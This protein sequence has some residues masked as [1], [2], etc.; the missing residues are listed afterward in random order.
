MDKKQLL[1][2]LLISAL[3]VAYFIYTKPDE[4]TIKAQQQ[5][6]ARLDSIQRLTDSLR[7]DSVKQLNQQE[8]SE[9]AA[10]IPDSLLNA[11]DSI[12]LAKRDS[13]LSTQNQQQF[14]AFAAHAQGEAER[15]VLENEFLRLE[16]L[17]KGARLISA[18]L[19]DYQTYHDHF[20]ENSE[21][22]LDLIHEGAA[23]LDLSFYSEGKQINTDDLYFEASPIDKQGLSFKVFAGAPD[24]YLEWRYFLPKESRMLDFSVH[25][26]N[27]ER[28]LDPGQAD[29]PLAWS[30]LAPSQELD[31]EIERSRTT[32]YYQTEDES[33]SRI[34][35]GGANEEEI[36]ESLRWIS[37]KQQ[38][39]CNALILNDGLFKRPVTAKAG[40]PNEEDSTVNMAFLANLSLPYSYQPQ[41]QVSMRW[42]LGPLH[43]QTLAT[44]EIGLEDQIDLGYI[45][46]FTWINK[47]LI[48]P[49]FNFF[50][51][52]GLGYGLIILLLT[53]IIK[54]LLSPLNFK[55]F[56]SSA[57]MRILK[58]EVDELSKK[59]KP[60]E[61]MKK[62]Q[63]VMTL[64]RQAGVNPLAGCLPML[65]QMPFLLAMFSFFP[66]AIELRQQGFLWAEDLS[67]YDSIL[68]LPFNIPFYGSHVSLF[69]LL[70]TVTTILYTRMTS[71]QMQTGANAQ[72][73]KIMMYVMPLIFLGVLNNYS[74]ALSYYY[75]LSNVVSIGITLA[76][77]KF[78]IDEDKLR[79]K[80]E[81]NKQNPKKK[82]K[83]MR[84]LEEAQKAKQQQARQGNAP[85]NRRGR[86]QGN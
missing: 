22:A 36:D 61:A 82:S 49:V 39:F 71:G 51:G 66:S 20:S 46:I 19:K 4:A 12:S 32:I 48:I 69:T 78:F 73:M 68:A 74:S 1:G 55:T 6:R 45:G 85:K 28:V 40:V 79:A 70:M 29:L 8:S 86:R 53:L 35:R 72:Q 44:Y 77:R 42:F 52:L 25:F 14:G 31:A 67:T 58:P 63:A 59:F 65:V 50:D 76:I 30:Q 84:R 7:L 13:L 21:E 24:S 64:Y 54:V 11:T 43:Y 56:V 3:M 41:E 27:L 23:F 47:Y 10:V 16:F 2:L 80:I 83:F 75:F 38:F 15:F 5:E 34:G 33:V 18:K 26:H 17:S 57:K 9:L 62:Q 60:E 81:A 37:F